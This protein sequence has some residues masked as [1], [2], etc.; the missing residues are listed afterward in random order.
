MER[1]TAAEKIV[2]FVLNLLLITGS[3]LCILTIDRGG[4]VISNPALYQSPDEST[5][6]IPVTQGADHPAGTP[7]PQPAASCLA[8]A[9]LASPDWLSAYLFDRAYTSLLGQTYTQAA[10]CAK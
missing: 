10:I 3:I 5:G 4:W 8:P 7:T 2:F 1:K 6:E 9:Q